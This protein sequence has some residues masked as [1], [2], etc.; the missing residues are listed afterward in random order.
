[1]T[2]EYLVTALTCVSCAGRVSSA[3]NA[4]DGVQDVQITL[5]PGG[6][7]TAGV[8]SSQS[9]SRTAV[10]DVVEKAGYQLTSA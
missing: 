4:L 3:L 2:A 9:L 7:S 1:M 10:Q 5:V 8:I 6:I